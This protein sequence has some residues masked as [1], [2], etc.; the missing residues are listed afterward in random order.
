MGGQSQRS[1]THPI[2]VIGLGMGGS[3]SRAEMERIVSAGVMAGGARLLERFAHLPSERIVISTPLSAALDRIDHARKRGERVVVLADGDPLFFGIGAA[4]VERFGREA[5]HFT[6]GVS[7]V[8]AA[9]ARIGLAWNDLPVVSL[10]GRSDS[11]PVMAAL[12][13]KGRAAVYTD[14]ENTPA[15]VARLLLERGL[16]TAAIWVLEELGGAGERVRRFSPAEAAQGEYSP[17]NLA[18]IEVSAPPNGPPVL[19]REDAAYEK[20]E[21][22]I[23][24]WPTR[25][26]A[27]AMLRLT[28]DGVLWDVGAGC[29]S[30]GI[31]ACALMPLGRVFAVER[32]PER[33]GFIRENISRYGAWQV[34][35]V[36]GE[37]PEAFTGLPDPDRVFVGGSLGRG[38]AALAEACR[39]LKPGGRIVANTVLLGSLNLAVGHFKDLGWVMETTQIQASHGLPLAED[40]HLVAD[41]PVFIIAADKP[42]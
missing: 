12:A 35:A 11:G 39:R 3:L 13:S 29:G 25:A 26:C 14:N 32:D 30:V 7:A 40:L 21:G 41:N 1:K 20:R 31:E 36:K 33:H 34:K 37:A 5:L 23:T 6:P 19:G 2:E 24:K 4:L 10:H 16:G 8:Q 17:L 38:T 28:R 9:C 18:I 22:L 42:A 15:S 27:L